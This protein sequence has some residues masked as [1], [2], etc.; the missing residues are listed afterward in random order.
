MAGSSSA[1]RSPDGNLSLGLGFG[2]GLDLSLGLLDL[3]YGSID[4]LLDL[5]GW[6][7]LGHLSSSGLV[8][9][10]RGVGL[11][12]GLGNGRRLLSLL[13]DLLATSRLLGRWRSGDSLNDTRLGVASLG[14]SL[15]VG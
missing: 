10:L 14:A 8:A 7:L 1:G 11:C 5:L 3:L 13:G 12:L 4:S 2:I 15:A 9:R 6:L